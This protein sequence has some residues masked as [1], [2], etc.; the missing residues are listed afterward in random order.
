[1]IHVLSLTLLSMS[2]RGIALILFTFMKRRQVIIIIVV[3][4]INIVVVIGLSHRR[5]QK[6]REVEIMLRDAT[7]YDGATGET[8]TAFD[9]QTNR[10][11]AEMKEETAEITIQKLTDGAEYIQGMILGAGVSMGF[12]DEEE[13]E[14]NHYRG[15]IETILSNRRF[16]KAYEDLQKMN[17]RQSTELLIRNL[18][19]NL[20]EL[21]IMLHADM[22]K[23]AQRR[24]IGG[25]PEGRILS[26]DSG[27]TYRPMSSPDRP[28]TRF[29]R[30]NAVFSY[31]LLAS[32]LEI[33]EVRP[34]VEE[35][36]EFAKAEYELFNSVSVSLD[37]ESFDLGAYSFKNNLI[38][39]SLYNPSLLIT[40]TF[41]DP[42]WKTA[43]KKRLPNE[44]L[45]NR[46]VV[47]YQARAIEQDKDAREGW[48][49][50]V[51]HDS[52]LKIRY[53]QGI[54]DAEF[55]DFFGK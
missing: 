3:L 52:M 17:R 53:Y 11:L 15:V 12:T 47:D 19:D 33:R 2:V 26:I 22:E 38:A 13:R 4:L 49:P 37:R 28:P 23:V 34:A 24:H 31:L 25:V 27:D 35:V 41:C 54:T 30:K 21:R 20:V 9:K 45:I 43:E 32:F 6:Q 1:M 51:P 46:E 50:I 10:W 44:K 39:D 40:A 36:I 42:T 7:R 48:I 18:R 16:R 8:I 29:G 14:K 5:A 55:N